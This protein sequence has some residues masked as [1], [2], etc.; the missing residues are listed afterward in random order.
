MFTWRRESAVRHPETQKAERG[1]R[2][3]FLLLLDVQG[4]G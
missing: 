4:E 2:P 1:Y 3:A